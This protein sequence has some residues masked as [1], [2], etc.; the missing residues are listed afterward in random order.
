MPHI[1]HWSL[2]RNQTDVARPRSDKEREDRP[3]ESD[4]RF[5]S[6]QPEGARPP[7]ESN[8]D[9]RRERARLDPDGNIRS[10]SG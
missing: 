8:V 4:R 1:H 3:G 10:H 9:E 6:V 7:S 2:A 5:R